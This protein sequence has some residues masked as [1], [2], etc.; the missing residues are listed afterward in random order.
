MGRRG[1]QSKYSDEKL[2]PIE[3]D[4]SGGLPDCRI[5]FN[6]TRAFTPSDGTEEGG[7][8]SNLTAAC[9]GSDW[10][11][12]PHRPFRKWVHKPAPYRRGEA[13]AP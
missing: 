8:V 7:A 5:A 13:Y 6:D 10:S 12:Q 9:I 11:W 2:T 4:A 1:P 3:E